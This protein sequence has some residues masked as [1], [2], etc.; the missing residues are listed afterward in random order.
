M[1]RFVGLEATLKPDCCL[2]RAAL[3]NMS[4]VKRFIATSKIENVRMPLKD[5]GIRMWRHVAEALKLTRE[6]LDST[7]QLWTSFRYAVDAAHHLETDFRRLLF[8]SEK[9]I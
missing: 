1:K 6:Q 3:T 2:R 9:H 7:S 5:E 8:M 4:N